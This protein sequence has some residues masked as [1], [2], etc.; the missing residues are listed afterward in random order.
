MNE[1]LE[2]SAKHYQGSVRKFMSQL[3]IYE[4]ETPEC[5]INEEVMEK[6]GKAVDD[7]LLWTRQVLL[8]EL[9]EYPSQ[10]QAAVVF[11]LP[12]MDREVSVKVSEYDRSPFSDEFES[13]T[14]LLETPIGSISKYL[15]EKILT[16]KD[17]PVFLLYD[18][19]YMLVKNIYHMFLLHDGD[20][21]SLPD[22]ELMEYHHIQ[23]PLGV[24][25]YMAIW[26]NL[27]AFLVKKWK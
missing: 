1:F 7:M 22:E 4:S 6:F 10:N 12:D 24:Y 17:N 21:S 20:M 26:Q 5:A 2:N 27:D 18:H 19:L 3:S 15:Y 16:I 25:R 8:M 23:D 13:S 14:E 11:R 9:M